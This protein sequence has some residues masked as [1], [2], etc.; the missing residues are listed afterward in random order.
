MCSRK[1][2]IPVVTCVSKRLVGD[3][4]NLVGDGANVLGEY[5]APTVLV[6]GAIPAET[7]GRFPSDSHCTEHQSRTCPEGMIGKDSRFHGYGYES[8]L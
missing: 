8:H 1:E 4:A 5:F 2:C 7:D 6:H 3:S